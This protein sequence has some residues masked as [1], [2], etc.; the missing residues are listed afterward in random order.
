MDQGIALV[1]FNYLLICTILLVISILFFRI[2]GNSLFSVKRNIGVKCLSMFG[3]YT[4]SA[5]TALYLVYNSCRSIVIPDTL[6]WFLIGAIVCINIAYTL[7]IALW[8]H[9]KSNNICSQ[10]EKL[11]ILDL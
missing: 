2:I 8:L 4:I 6:I 5:A 10:L 11:K 1:F 3:L 9:E 7:I